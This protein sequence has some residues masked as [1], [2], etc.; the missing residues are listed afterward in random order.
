MK[1][2][3]KQLK[4]KIL[5]VLLAAA[6]FGGSAAVALPAVGVDVGI[7]ASAATYQNFEYE[8]NS[9]GGITITKYTGSDTEVVIP[10]KID[11]KAVTSIGY[12][13]FLFCTSLTSVT[14]PDNVTSIGDKAF[15]YYLDLESHESEKI[16]NCTIYGKPDSAAETYANENKFEFVDISPEEIQTELR[17]DSA[18]DESEVSE[19]ST[20][21]SRDEIDDIF[22]VADT[23]PTA[24]S[25]NNNILMVIIAIIL[26]G[27]SGG[28]V[29]MLIIH[30]K[31]A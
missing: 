10:S 7:T 29:A 21:V 24:P 17:D 15:G 14:I 16:N 23:Q 30:I 26:I 28:A 22:P 13:A 20:E 11:G 19:I 18:A 8:E 2:E 27:I 5:A 3:V 6:M 25:D 12:E 1:K 31:K 4:R 9:D